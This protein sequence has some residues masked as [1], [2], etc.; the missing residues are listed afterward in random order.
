MKNLLIISFLLINLELFS[1]DYGIDLEKSKI[2]WTG[3]EITTSSHYGTLK[4]VEGEINLQPDAVSGKVIVDME[5]LSVDD[6][7]GGSK[8]RLEGHLRSDDFFSVSSHKSSTIEVKS[9]KKNGDDFDV[10]GVLTIKGISHP[11]S[12]VL[13]VDEKIATSKLTFDRSKYDVRFRSGT[14][15]ENLGDKLILDDIELEVELHLN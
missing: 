14:F 12:F 7:T 5:S 9:S 2:K 1:Q 6:L 15:F 8:A 13:S 10:D 4:F 11:I 3:K